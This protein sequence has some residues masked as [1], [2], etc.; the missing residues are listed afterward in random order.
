MGETVFVMRR[1]KKP[2]KVEGK[3]DSLGSVEFWSPLSGECYFFAC[4]RV[5]RACLT[6][7]HNYMEVRMRDPTCP[8]KHIWSV[9]AEENIYANIQ[10]YDFPVLMDF[11]LGNK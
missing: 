3:P 2:I 8:L 11:D 4:N 6:P 9:V 7:A 5:P 1:N 10:K